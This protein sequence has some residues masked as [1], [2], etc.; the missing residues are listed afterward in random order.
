MATKLADASKRTRK[1]SR[2]DIPVT[3]NPIDIAMVAAVSGKPLP[4]IA[5]RVL[6]EEARLI[7]AQCT[8]LRLREVGERVRAA[9]WAILALAALV[10]VGLIVTVVVKAARSDALVVESF[11]VPPAMASQGLTGE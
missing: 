9:L 10:I 2:E 5:R 3:P 7:R 8:E 4:D 1:P 6:E 11:R